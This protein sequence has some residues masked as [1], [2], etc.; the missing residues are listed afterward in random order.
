MNLRG[1]C[2]PVFTITKVWDVPVCRA[3]KGFKIRTSPMEN[4]AIGSKPDVCNNRVETICEFPEVFDVFARISGTKD[5]DFFS[6]RV[7]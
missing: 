2:R 4:S 3:E 1:L 5:L 6:Y 7:K